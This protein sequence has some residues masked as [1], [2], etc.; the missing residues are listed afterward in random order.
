M[1]PPPSRS[2]SSVAVYDDEFR[3]YRLFIG[4]IAP[5]VTEHDVC[6]YFGYFG[7]VKMVWLARDPPGFAY[8][9]YFDRNVAE[10]ARNKTHMVRWYNR[11][12]KVE[13]AVPRGQNPRRFVCLY[14]DFS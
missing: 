9:V 11:L 10:T 5:G 8:V 2:R 13:F 12:I 7:E 3:G 6:K 1:P 4:N 14:F